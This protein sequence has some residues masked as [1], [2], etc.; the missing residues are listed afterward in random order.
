VFISACTT[1]PRVDKRLK[2]EI[3]VR[4]GC[5]LSPILFNLRKEYL[6][7]LALEGSGIQAI[8]TLKD[9]DG[10]VLLA[11][12]TVLQYVINGLVV[13]LER[14][15]GMVE[16]KEMRILKQLSLIQVMIG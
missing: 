16:N 13:N 3:G 12:G 8:C 2:I 14:H 4:K 7:S 9:A 5:C 1:G 6:N 10:L 15:Y 11:K